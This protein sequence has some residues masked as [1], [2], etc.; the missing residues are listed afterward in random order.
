MKDLKK[1]LLKRIWYWEKK[2][3][4]SEIVITGTDTSTKDNK[5]D[6]K[7]I[8]KDSNGHSKKNPQAE[9]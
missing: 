9:R 5:D 4:E 1:I 2:K 6:F 3:R 8:D 7:G